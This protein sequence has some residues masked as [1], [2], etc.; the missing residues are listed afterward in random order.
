MNAKQFLTRSFAQGYYFYNLNCKINWCID[1]EKGAPK[2][3]NQ[4]WNS[5]AF[6]CVWNGN[7]LSVEIASPEKFN[8]V[9]L[10]QT[11]V[12]Q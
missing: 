12:H 11:N 4:D 8:Q 10:E 2:N 6:I 9:D 7:P 1:P 5:V 3:R